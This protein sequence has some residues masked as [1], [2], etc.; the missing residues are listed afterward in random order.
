MSEDQP[1][2][3]QRVA[4]P[5]KPNRPAGPRLGELLE[6]RGHLKREVLIDTLRH[7]RASGGRRTSTSNRKRKKRR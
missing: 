2:F 3:D 6:T 7:Q 5:M 4:V 1:V